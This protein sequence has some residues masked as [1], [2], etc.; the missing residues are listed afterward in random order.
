MGFGLTVITVALDESP[1]AVRPSID[2]ASPTHPSLIDT[3]HV[4]ADLYNIVNVPTAVWIDEI[5]NIV[6]PNDVAFGDDRFRDFTHVASGPHL[7]AL[8]A[9]ITR[10]ALPFI[11][12]EVRGHMRLP[13]T[14]DQLARAEFRIASWLGRRGRREAA[15]RHFVRAGDLAP[16]DFTIRRGSLPMRG[17]DPRGPAFTEMHRDWVRRGNSYYVQLSD[18]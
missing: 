9:W 6:R 5:G 12:E 7:D 4:V 13:T 11:N 16:H 15:E 17:L 3:D 2:K 18:K 10:E 14:Q 1:E 8:Q